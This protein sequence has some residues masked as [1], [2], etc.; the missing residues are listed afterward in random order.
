MARSLLVTKLVPSPADSGGKLRSRAVAELLAELGPVDLVAFDEADSDRRPLEERGIAVYTVPRPRRGSLGAAAGGLT[1]LGTLSGARFW[2]R[3]LAATIERLT[4]RTDYD[5]VQVEYAALAPY[6]RAARGGRVRV[7]DL[8]NVE[9]A[10][11]ASRARRAPLPLRAVLAAEARAL[12]RV[13]R[14]AMADFDVVVTVSE[15][16]TARLPAPAAGS[17]LMCPNGWWPGECLPPADGPTVAFVGLLGWGP[18]RDAAL[19]LGREIWPEVERRVPGARLLLVGREPDEAVCALRS[20]SIE[21]VP[22]PPDVRPW[23]ARAAVAV[24]PLRSGGGSRLKILEALDAGRPVVATPLGAEG[25]ERL[26]GRGVFLAE[27]AHGLADTIAELLLSY[28]RGRRAGL[29]GHAEVAD[30]FAWRRTLEPL[31][32]E[33]ERRLEAGSPARI[34]TGAAA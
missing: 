2:S 19:W 4:A 33:L 13:E 21:V 16:E 29:D 22:S 18:N 23:L 25:L 17:V 8:H 11:M 30:V 6:A 20:G 15:A 27:S 24:A 1:S 14:R 3:E 28:D 31:R 34:A 7:L 10:L 9:S 5:V 12:G 32:T 26:I